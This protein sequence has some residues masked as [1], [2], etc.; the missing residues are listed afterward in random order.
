MDAMKRGDDL[1]MGVSAGEPRGIISDLAGA[2]VAAFLVS[3]DSGKG[4][5]VS[6]SL[7]QIDE[8]IA[9]IEKDCP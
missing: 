4:A 2:K 3:S 7:V 5:A 1:N 9:D 6:F 8:V